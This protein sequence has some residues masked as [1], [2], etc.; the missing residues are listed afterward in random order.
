MDRVGAH[1][2]THHGDGDDDPVVVS[3]GGGRPCPCASSNARLE[4]A[5]VWLGVGG[6]AGPF[7]LVQR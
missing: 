4:A 2:L 3:H 7:T 5:G 6:S 1:P